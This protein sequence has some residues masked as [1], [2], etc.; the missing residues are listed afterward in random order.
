MLTRYKSFLD[1]FSLDDDSRSKA[2]IAAA[3]SAKKA[4]GM[5]DYYDYEALA[6]ICLYRR[7]K[8]IFEIGTYLGN[9]SDFFLKLLPDCRVVSIAFINPKLNFFSKL[10]NN[11]DLPKRKIGS[12]VD[13][14]RRSRFTQIYG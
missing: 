3:E 13:P 8:N 1:Y 5:M 12:A 6:A 2:K 14:D 7:P 4:Q 9:T 11:S 10:S